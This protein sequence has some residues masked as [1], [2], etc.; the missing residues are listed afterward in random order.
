[1]NN[2]G[3]Y[4]TQQFYYEHPQCTFSIPPIVSSSSAPTVYYTYSTDVMSSTPYPTF[5][6]AYPSF[7]PVPCYYPNTTPD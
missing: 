3:N 1:M 2:S 7:S 5:P 6:Q 4:E